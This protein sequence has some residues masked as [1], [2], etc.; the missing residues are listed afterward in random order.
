MLD[1]IHTTY[2]RASN[3]VYL[4]CGGAKLAELKVSPLLSS[5]V[6]NDVRKFAE[7]AATNAVKAFVEAEAERVVNGSGDSEPVGLLHAGNQLKRAVAEKDTDVDEALIERR[8]P[9]GVATGY[10][11]GQQVYYLTNT[12]RVYGRVIDR[13]VFSREGCVATF[14]GTSLQVPV[15]ELYTSLDAAVSMLLHRIED[16]ERSR[17]AK[18]EDT[19][20]E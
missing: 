7:A 2:D 10:E 13:I 1:V 3:T 8:A 12:S 19:A 4:L 17:F 18:V 9:A 6:V 20:D 15:A 11:P 5:S 16:R 14:G